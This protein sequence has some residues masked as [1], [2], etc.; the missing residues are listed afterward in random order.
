MEPKAFPQSVIQFGALSEPVS[1]ARMA[2]STW[3]SLAAACLALC[4][5]SV[6]P[7]ANAWAIK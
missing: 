4:T 7:S 3:V 5:T 6:A 1:A 2:A